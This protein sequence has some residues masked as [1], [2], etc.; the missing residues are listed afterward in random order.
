MEIG[1]QFGLPPLKFNDLVHLAEDG[2]FVTYLSDLICGQLLA[3]RV[4]T[5]CVPGPDPRATP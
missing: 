4:T 3:Q 5:S 2:P 1:H